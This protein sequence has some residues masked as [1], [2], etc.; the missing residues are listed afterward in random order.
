[1][2]RYVI[3]SPEYTGEM[4]FGYDNEGVLK[5]YEN[6]A[7]LKTEHMVWLA[8]NF[9]FA[10]SDLPKIVSK[11]KVTEITDL[12][13]EKFWKDYDYK[14]GNKKAV[15]RLWYRLSESDRIAVLDHLPKYRYHLQIN[16]GQAKAY[17][18]TF[19]NQ[20]RWENEYK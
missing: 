13:F 5:Y 16:R 1:M 15:E 17:P 8:R 2:R 7:E 4:I 6:N 18:Q 3:T 19:I 9:P 10:D 20:R 12:S 11:G 14:V